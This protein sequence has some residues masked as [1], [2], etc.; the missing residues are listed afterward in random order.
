MENKIISN[1][2]SESEIKDLYECLNNRPSEVQE[3]LGRVRLDYESTDINLLPKSILSNMHDFA[4]DYFNSE[5]SQY[6]LQYF[7][8][9]EYNNRFGIPRLGPH[10]DQTSFTASVLYQLD[11]NVEWELYF[12]GV[13][14]VLNNNQAIIANVRD[15]DHWRPDK[16]MSDDQYVKMIFFHFVN[17]KDTKENVVT[18]EQLHEINMKWAHITGYKESDRTY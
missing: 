9:V 6:Y 15:Q 11:A 12:D 4:N 18:P 7:S 2:F 17:L 3:F 1:V 5:D 10:K 16:E 8:Y 14:Y 13:P